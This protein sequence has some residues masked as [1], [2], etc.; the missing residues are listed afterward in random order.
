MKKIIPIVFLIIILFDLKV[1]S[2]TENPD[3]VKRTVLI[4]PFVNKNKIA[5]YD[6]LSEI[7][8]ETL[9]SEL[10]Q[11]EIFE[12]TNFSLSRNK[13]KEYKT[14]DFLDLK[15]VNNIADQLNADIV[16]TGQ[17]LIYE[18]KIMI[19]IHAIDIFT[20]ELIVLTK[21]EGQTGIDLFNL[22]DNASKDMKDKMEIKFPMVDKRTYIDKSNKNIKYVFTPVKKAGIGFISSGSSL[23][24][25]GFPVLIYDLA[26]YS[27]ILKANRDRYLDT[28][29]YYYE[30][31][32]SYYIFVTLLIS[33]ICFSGIGLILL[34]VGLPLLFVKI[35]ES[36]NQKISLI[37]G[38]AQNN[39]FYF[40]RND[41]N[42]FIK[43]RI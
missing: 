20:G 34:S 43:I 5:E 25:I 32:Q 6:Y 30:Y 4:L 42:L 13:Y 40:N 35:K 36:R 41:F 15:V 16:A 18:N 1:F 11:S 23:F 8:M 10:L 9:R 29:N 33:S 14:E 37:F 24:L 28:K 2:L 39:F 7:I 21:V 17:Y 3:L 22:I 27:S 26:G 19:L 12:F 38:I 31:D